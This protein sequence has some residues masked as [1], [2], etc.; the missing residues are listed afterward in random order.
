VLPFLLGVESEK[1]AQGGLR[2][3]CTIHESLII[4]IK[5]LQSTNKLAWS[6]RPDNLFLFMQMLIS[7]LMMSLNFHGS[8]IEV[9][10]LL[11]VM[12]GSWELTIAG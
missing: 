7:D 8:A 11:P 3:G 10:V 12:C 1:K 6:F 4:L 9:C 2:Q 5:V